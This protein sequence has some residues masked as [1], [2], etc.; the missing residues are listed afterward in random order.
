VVGYIWYKRYRRK[1]IA[2][3]MRDEKLHLN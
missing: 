1:D 2:I 3:D